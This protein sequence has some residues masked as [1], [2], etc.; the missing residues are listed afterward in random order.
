MGGYN[1]KRSNSKWG[2]TEGSEVK[3]QKK[4]KELVAVK[5]LNRTSCSDRHWFQTP[6]LIV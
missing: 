6:T 2:G 4:V 5:A 1:L 3:E